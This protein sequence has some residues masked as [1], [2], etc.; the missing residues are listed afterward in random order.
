MIRC[1][2]YRSIDSL[3]YTPVY[4]KS[5]DPNLAHYQVSFSE[6]GEGNGDYFEDNFSALGRVYKWIKP[7]TLTTGEIIRRGRFEPVVV[8]LPP[9]KR[10]IISL[11]GDVKIGNNGQLYSEV[12]FS[13]LDENSFSSI[14]DN[15]N[16]G[17]AAKVGFR[18]NKR[19]GI[20]ERTTI[21]SQFEGEYVE[22]KFVFIERFRDVEFERNWNL[23]NV[24]IS[25]DQIM[26]KAMFGVANE[27][28]LSINANSNY[29]YVDTTFSGF[30]QALSGGIKKPSYQINYTGSYLTSESFEKSIFYRHKSVA[31]KTFGQITFG[32]KDEMEQNAFRH[33]ETDTLTFNSYNFYDWQAYVKTPDT[34]VHSVGLFYRERLDEKPLSNQMS[35]AAKATGFGLEYK[36]AR[37]FKNIFKT[38]VE[39]RDLQILDSALINQTPENAPNP[40]TQPQE[41]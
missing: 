29:F 3:G 37:S 8:L 21:K 2:F 7:D 23:N 20:K 27:S 16:I 13:N 5:D 6:V 28:G 26:G 36:F 4:V 14:D 39:Y 35:G 1:S 30:N 12:A 25:S 34:T 24:L 38:R 19:L 40:L 17:L 22:S 10:Q 41:R 18:S 33:N 15:D 31:E 11:G 32:F 9:K